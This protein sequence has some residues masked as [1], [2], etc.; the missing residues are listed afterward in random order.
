MNRI[1]RLVWSKNSGTFVA[2]SEKNASQGKASGRSTAV[3]GTV[4]GAL[5]ALSAGHAWATPSC[6]GALSGSTYQLS[7]TETTTCQLESGKSLT[8]QATG[9]IDVRSSL[10]NSEQTV[11]VDGVS[12]G[13]ITNNGNLYSLSAGASLVSGAITVFNGATI[14]DGIKNTGLISGL[15]SNPGAGDA[16]GVTVGHGTVNSGITNSGTIT[17]INGLR[18]GHGWGNGAPQGYAGNTI[19]NGGI[20]NQTNGIIRGASF[21]ISAQGSADFSVTINGGINNAGLI[22]SD[23]TLGANSIAAIELN[24][25][26]LDTLVN[27]VGGRIVGGDALRLFDS[28]V[29]GDIVNRGQ[30]GELAE[31]GDGGYGVYLDNTTINGRVFNASTGVI[32]NVDSN[33][34]GSGVN[35]ENTTIVGGLVNEGSITGGRY[36]I[37][38]MDDATLNIVNS[39]QILATGSTSNP[40]GEA[41]IILSQAELTGGITNLV[42]G[43][44]RSSNISDDESAG[45][46]LYEEASLTGVINNAGRIDGYHGIFLSSESSIGGVVNTGVIEGLQGA[47]IYLTSESAVNGNIAN[48]AGGIIRG[49][50][51]AD[52]N[53]G[54]RLASQSAITGTITNAGLIEGYQGIFLASDS[55]LGGI[56]NTGI[57]KGLTGAA[58]FLDDDSQITGD[59]INQ[60]SGTIQ[61][62][63]HGVWVRDYSE[64][65]GKITNSGLITA[66]AGNAIEVGDASYFGDESAV[67]GGIQNNAGGRIIGVNGSGIVVN[68]DSTIGGVGIVNAGLIQ[69]TV[70][71]LDLRNTAGAFEITNTGTLDGDAD[72][73]INTLN[74]NGTTGHVTGNVIGT[75]STVNVNGTFAAEGLFNVGTFNVASGGTFNMNDSYSVTTSNGFTNSGVLNVGTGSQTI[76]GNYTQTGTFRFTLTDATNYGRLT[77]YGQSINATVDNST[78]NVKLNGAPGARIN[79]VIVVGDPTGTLSANN[80]TV[81]DNS[82]LYNFTADTTRDAR[83]LDLVTSSDPNGIKNAIANNGNTAGKGAAEVLQ[84]MF[85]TSIPQAMQPVFDKLGGLNEQQLSTAVTQ[86]TPALQGAAPQA[87]INALRSMNKIIQSRIESNQGLSSGDEIADKYLWLRVFGNEGSQNNQNG[88]PGFKSRTSGLVLGTDRPITSALRAGAAFTYA[89]SNISGNTPSLSH[90]GVDTYEIVTYASYNINQRTD[91]N[92]QFDVGQNNAESSRS[93]AFDGSTARANF[94]SLAWHS[95]VGLGH[96][97][98]LSERST[99]TPSLRFDYTQMKTDGYTERDAGPLNLRVDGSTFKEFLLT[100]DIKGAH[101]LN[102]TLKLVGNASAG[103]DFLNKQAQTTSTFTGGGSSFVTNGLD[104][105]PWVYRA[106]FGLIKQDKKGVEYSA[107]YDAEARTSGYF[108]Q[109][110]SARARWAF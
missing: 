30:I 93:I 98:V 12:A 72:I 9:S 99:M 33:G 110:V 27:Q 8:V 73:G 78:V 56:N 16:T 31:N 38:V 43:I 4:A 34:N 41:G 77:L 100:A 59:V 87:G 11:I 94:S 10:I 32:R 21:G 81:T 2:V 95:S 40:G 54:I 62:V 37:A 83:E 14:G 109:T 88:V 20:V 105:S 65:D 35:I 42:G 84:N 44:I 53:A 108:N 102:D 26:H 104:V 52:D 76:Y 18:L 51:D 91:L 106:G 82:A 17:G 60:A 13:G 96:T 15:S 45:I 66:T 101:Y 71:S 1:Y 22:Q 86:L 61:G 49:A 29:S 36:G 57:I 19:I 46:K 63:T 68:A 24:Y 67:T 25:T 50:N 79:G 89:R 80:V 39:G 6:S 7:S 75:G 69:G 5:L 47:G 48:Q 70:N 3:V 74:L 103:Y 107:R 85:N 58:I 55:S 64:I 92:L 23:S 28:T 90:I 97:L